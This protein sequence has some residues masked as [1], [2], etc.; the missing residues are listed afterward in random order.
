MR[1][2]RVLTAV[3]TTVDSLSF[4]E[5]V[6]GFRVIL[7]SVSDALG[8]SDTVSRSVSLIRA[9]SDS[10]TLADIADR[11]ATFVRI[12]SDAIGLTDS[13]VRF[14]GFVRAA[15]DAISFSEFVEGFPL[16]I[17]R[18]ATEALAFA[19]SAGRQVS[20]FRETLESFSLGDTVVRLVFR[21]GENIATLGSILETS[22]S[23]SRVVGDGIARLRGSKPG[24]RLRGG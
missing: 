7:R 22:I 24:R 21:A 9:I 23:R 14:A 16:A 6:D 1:K 5:S 8:L 11:V 15:A 20:L 2:P 18:F 10:I 17:Q 19:D 12:T 13:V 4:A 3:R